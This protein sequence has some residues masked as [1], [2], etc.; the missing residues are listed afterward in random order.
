MLSDILSEESIYIIS[1]LAFAT[2][3]CGFTLIYVIVW[4]RRSQIEKRKRAA[5][6]HLHQ[7]QRGKTRKRKARK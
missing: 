6:R 5:I 2:F 4:E 1:G 7:L 3:V